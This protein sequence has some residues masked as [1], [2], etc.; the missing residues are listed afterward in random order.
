MGPVG[1][2]NSLQQ[3]QIIASNKFK[4]P[5]CADQTNLHCLYAKLS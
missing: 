2:L 1:V 5:F 3:L 4:N